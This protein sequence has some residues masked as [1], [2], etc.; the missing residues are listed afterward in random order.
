MMAVDAPIEVI[1]DVLARTE[2]VYITNLN[3]LHQ[4]VLG[5]NTEKVKAIGVEL[6]ANGYRNTLLR[7]SMAFHSPIMRCIHDELEEFVAGIQFHAPKI[8]VISNTT[9]KVFPKTQRKSRES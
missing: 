9:T 2:D 7:V 1:D 5:G 6:K 3:S 8:P 4:I